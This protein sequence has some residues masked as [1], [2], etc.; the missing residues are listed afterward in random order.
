VTYSESTVADEIGERFIPVQLN[1]QAPATKPVSERYRQVWTPDLRLLGPDG[2]EL[3][4]WNGFLPPFEFLPQ[5]LVAEAHGFLRLDDHR[6][7][8]TIFDEV[9]R[10]FPTSSVAP[11]AQYFL[12][13]SKYKASHEGADLLGGWKLLQARY[14]DS[15]WRVKQSFSE[16]G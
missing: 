9:L 1:V 4:R 14:P 10:R 3:Y 12:A 16:D 13:V 7:A 5:L 2:F 11:E 8:A 6:R 15:I